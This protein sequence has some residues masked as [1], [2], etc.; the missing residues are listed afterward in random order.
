MNTNCSGK[1]SFITITINKHTENKLLTGFDF[2]DYLELIKSS[3]KK[4]EINS[5][6]LSIRMPV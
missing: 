6:F 5:A 3:N 1:Y 4:S 2:F